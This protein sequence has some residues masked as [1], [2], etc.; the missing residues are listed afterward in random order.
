VHAR[1]EWRRRFLRFLLSAIGTK[2]LAKVEGA[3]GIENIPKEGAAILMMNHIAL[4]DPLAVLHFTPRNIVPL[5]KVEAIH[6]PIISIFPRIWWVIPV[7]RGDVDRRAIRG[8]LDVLRAGE[9]ILIAPEATR[10]QQ[11]QRGKEGVAYLASR[12]GAP[13]VPVAIAGTP[14]FPSL[15]ISP[16]WR[17]PG[18]HVRFGKPFYYKQDL[19]RPGREKL[20]LMTDEAMYIL[21]EMLPEDR[22]GVYSDFSQ[23]TQQTIEWS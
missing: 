4:L 18:I 15:P 13:V 17:E 8:A 20:R 5:S 3:E 10:N 21:A 23:A 22:R 2:T 7:D 14:G 19:K 6:I 1:Y 12:S 9:I 16:R 11:L